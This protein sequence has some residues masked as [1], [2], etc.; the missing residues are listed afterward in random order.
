[1]RVVRAQI[2][3]RYDVRQVPE[4]RWYPIV[5]DREPFEIGE[6]GIMINPIAGMSSSPC[7]RSSRHVQ[8][9]REVVY[10]SRHRDG[11]QFVDSNWSAIE[12]ENQTQNMSTKDGYQAYG[13]S[14]LWTPCLLNA[15]FKLLLTT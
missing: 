5:S 3:T 7:L 15:V 2:L 1:M 12:H 13:T 14:A 4:F 6:T 10:Q 8:A 11:K 9:V